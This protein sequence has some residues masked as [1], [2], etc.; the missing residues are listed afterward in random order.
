MCVCFTGPAPNNTNL[1]LKGI[2]AMAA[3]ARLKLMQG[4]GDVAAAYLG[5]A[6]DYAAYWMTNALESNTTATTHYLRQFNLP[7]TFSLKY[8]MLYHDL[9]DLQVFPPSVMQTEFEYYTTQQ[10][11]TYGT[12]LDD[13]H[14]YTLVEYLGALVGVASTCGWLHFPSLLGCVSMFCCCSGSILSLFLAL[15]ACDLQ[16]Q[17]LAKAAW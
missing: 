2:N 3:Y 13:R 8:N 4:Q 17:P 15:T 6:T 10:W 9:L 5:W 7:G 11:Y 16:A 1:A 12:P 14:V